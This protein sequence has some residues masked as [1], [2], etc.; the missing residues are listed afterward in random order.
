MSGGAVRALPPE[1]AENASCPPRFMFTW[2]GKSQFLQFSHLLLELQSQIAPI[3]SFA[4]QI[5]D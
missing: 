1:P 4:P 5:L 3:V 2:S